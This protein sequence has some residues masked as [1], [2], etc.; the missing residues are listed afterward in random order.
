MGD[1]AVH[2]CWNCIFSWISSTVRYDQ[3]MLHGKPFW[4]HMRARVM[5]G[6]I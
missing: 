3:Y 4:N 6:Q 2:N 1:I 5:F